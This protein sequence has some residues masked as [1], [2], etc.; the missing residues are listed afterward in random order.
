MVQPLAT[1]LRQTRLPTVF[2]IAGVFSGSASAAWDV[3]PVI[4]L[5]SE[6]NDNVPL[7]EPNDGGMVSTVTGQVTAR[8]LADS[9]RLDL[10]AGA[11]FTDYRGVEF[12]DDNSAQFLRFDG[13]RTLRRGAFGMQAGA[14]QDD[15]RRIYSQIG[16]GDLL[17]TS[18]GVFLD[19]NADA[20]LG[21]EVDVNQEV[22]VDQIDRTNVYAKPYAEF[23]F[24]RQNVGR[25]Y[26]AYASQDVDSLGEQLGLVDSD[27][28]VVGLD[29][30]SQLSQRN[31]LGID[32]SVGELSADNRPDADTAEIRLGWSHQASEN[33]EY[34]IYGGAREVDSNRPNTDKESGVLLRFELERKTQ[35]GR[36]RVSLERSLYPSAYGRIIEGDT[37]NINYRNNFTRRFA[38]RFALNAADLEPDDP[39]NIE[40]DR[41]FLS[42]Q[43]EF[44]WLFSETISVSLGYSYRWSERERDRLLDID[45]PSAHGVS[46]A[47]EYHP[48]RRY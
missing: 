10:T 13:R 30:E 28:S 21:S 31:S 6:Y 48:L 27:R 25:I 37:L 45:D 17:D 36:L 29:F 11:D 44:I 23:Q 43:P 20:P 15:Y 26:Y 32:L 16:Q 46:L 5:D 7:G 41:K 18:D 3:R 24:S 12:Y 42:A 8:W 47:L 1:L 33:L 9:N 19:G 34:T 38:F 4:K 2:L 39:I 40:D 14:R 35:T 22:A